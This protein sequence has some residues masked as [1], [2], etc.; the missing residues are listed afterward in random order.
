MNRPAGDAAHAGGCAHPVRDRAGEA[1]RGDRDG[2]ERAGRAGAGAAASVR[3]AHT[4]ISTGPCL[5]PVGHDGTERRVGRPH[6][7]TEPTRYD[8]GKNKCHTVKNVLL[9]NAVL[10]ILFLRETYAGR[11]HDTWMAEATP[12][13]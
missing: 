5:P 3:F 1:P 13:P 8:R 12:Y 2:R 7:P 6:D 11:P 9:I 4:G 10:T